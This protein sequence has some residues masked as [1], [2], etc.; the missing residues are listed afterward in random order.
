MMKG[1]AYPYIPNSTNL[2]KQKMIK[3]LGISSIDDLYVSIPDSLRLKRPLNLPTPI[4][5]EVELDRHVAEVLSK[6]I[7]TEEFLSFLGAAAI[8]TM[9]QQP[10]M[11][12]TLAMSF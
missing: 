1:I 10:V 7:S 9:C 11:K 12:S 5:S 6:N 8:T 4:L 3:D 2:A